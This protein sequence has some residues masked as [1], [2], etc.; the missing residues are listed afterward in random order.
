MS[1]VKENA[2]KPRPISQSTRE[3]ISKASGFLLFARKDSRPDTAGSSGQK[4]VGMFA[5]SR[6]GRPDSSETQANVVRLS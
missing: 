1:E 4:P 3:Q 2:P 6:S 5:S